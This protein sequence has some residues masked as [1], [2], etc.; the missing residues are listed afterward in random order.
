VFVNAGNTLGPIRT[1][2]SLKAHAVVRRTGVLMDFDKDKRTIHLLIETPGPLT[3]TSFDVEK[4]VHVRFRHTT[5]VLQEKAAFSD[6]GKL[7]HVSAFLDPDTKTIVQIDA[8]YPVC[9]RKVV[10]FDLA[11]GMLTFEDENSKA[12]TLPLAAETSLFAAGKELKMSQLAKGKNLILGLSVD[13]TKVV[14]LFVP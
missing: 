13:R 14:A 6:L 5:R 12:H 10:D 7:L 9:T 2:E 1:A 11:K 3:M 4:D 8:E